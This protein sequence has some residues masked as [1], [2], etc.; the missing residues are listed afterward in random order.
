MDSNSSI[1]IFLHALTYPLTRL[2]AFFMGLLAGMSW[3]ILVG[4]LLVPGYAVRCG[5]HIMKGDYKLPTWG[6]DDDSLVS[7]SITAL[8]ILIIYGVINYLISLVI[9]TLLGAVPS[10]VIYDPYLAISLAGFVTFIVLLPLSMMTYLS[11]MIFVDWNDTRRALNPLNAFGL[12][13]AKPIVFLK[14]AILDYV[15]SSILWIPITVMGIMTLAYRDQ[16]VLFCPLAILFLALMGCGLF[17]SLCVRMY[18]WARYYGMVIG[19]IQGQHED[20]MP[21]R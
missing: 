17:V 18:I 10:I 20:S 2:S 3:F 7:N 19:S 8:I 11:L 21:N 13:S 12:L 4:I 1:S 15:A 5:R 6:K 14:A 9:R 16:I